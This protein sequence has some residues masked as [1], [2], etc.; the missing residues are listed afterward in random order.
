MERRLSI[1]AERNIFFFSSP[2]SF[3][4]P[5]DKEGEINFYRAIFI[6]LEDVI[7]HLDPYMDVLLCGWY[8]EGLVERKSLFL[9]N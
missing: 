3:Y 4:I 8:D 2:Y 6:C 7:Q 5:L 9:I 1:R